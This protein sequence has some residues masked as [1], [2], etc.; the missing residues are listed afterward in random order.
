MGSMNESNI[1]V[2]FAVLTNFPS[3]VVKWMKINAKPRMGFKLMK[4]CKY[5]QHKEFPFIVIDDL[6]RVD[7]TWSYKILKRRKSKKVEKLSNRLWLTNVLRFY[8]SD[9]N[10]SDFINKI[11]VCDIKEIDFMS[12]KL[13]FDEFKFLTFN[14]T[15]ERLTMANVTVTFKNGIHVSLIDIFGCI[16]NIIKFCM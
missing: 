9:F 3:D 4:V 2:N 15:L 7:G 1:S 16:P 8:Y 5:F 6:T 14:G 12:Q 10:M 11:V 13:L